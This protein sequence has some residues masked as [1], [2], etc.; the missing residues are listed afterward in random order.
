MLN[1]KH[2]CRIVRRSFRLLCVSRFSFGLWSVD[3]PLRLQ[4]NSQA[5][6]SWQPKAKQSARGGAAN[7]KTKT[8]G[9]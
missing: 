6:R 9:H 7:P 3:V 2:I 4:R 1:L 8:L 5:G